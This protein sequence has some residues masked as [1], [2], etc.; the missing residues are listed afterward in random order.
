MSDGYQEIN[1]EK[2]GVITDDLEIVDEVVE[3]VNEEVEEA[4]KPKARV[5]VVAEDDENE[6]VIEG[7]GAEATERKKLTRSDRLKRQRDN[8]ARQNADLQAELQ[9][10]RGKT[11]KAET[12]SLEAANIGLDFYM[13]TLDADM[14]A[15]RVEFD[16]AFDSGDRDKLFG[17]QLKMTELAAEKKQAEREKRL[18]PTKA[19]PDGKEAQPSTPASPPRGAPSKVQPLAEDWVDRN[20]TWFQ[21]DSAMTAAAYAIDNDMVKEGFAPSDPEYFDELDKRVRE[22]FPHKFP[23]KAR[24]AS[25]TIQNKGGSTATT[26]GKVR[27]VITPADREM[28]NHLGLDITEYARSKARREQSQNTANQYTEIF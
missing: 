19:K 10:L 17:V 12:E 4:S 13:K 6:E 18:I 3:E 14:K 8:Y 21:K 23:A 11:V 9:E 25:P 24:P 2:P 7:E 20:K 1:L 27:V 28:A 5:P 22:A 15:L 16:Q 26:G